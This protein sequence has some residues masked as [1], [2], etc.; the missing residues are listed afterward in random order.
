MNC[1]GLETYG[2]YKVREG[3]GMP[4]GGGALPA[5]VRGEAKVVG[6]QRHAQRNL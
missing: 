2:L 1:L 4:R 5:I 3:E 6:K